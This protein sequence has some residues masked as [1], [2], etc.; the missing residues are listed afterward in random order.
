M[1]IYDAFV[2]GKIWPNRFFETNGRFWLNTWKIIRYLD[3][4]YLQ[5]LRGAL[6]ELSLRKRAKSEH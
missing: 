4:R 2:D 1:V 5:T 6:L 3:R